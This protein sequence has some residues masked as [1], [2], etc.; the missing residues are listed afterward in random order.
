VVLGDV[1]DEQGAEVASSLGGSALFAHL[2][3]TSPEDWQAV[4]ARAVGTF[5]KLTALVNN[6]GVHA[7]G[8]IEEMALVEYERI[9]GVNQIGCWLGMKYAAP[10]IREA[11]GGAIVNISSTAGLAGMA[12]RS[13][14]GATKW[15]IR[16]MSKSAALELGPSRIRVNCVLPGAVATSMMGDLGDEHFRSQ[17]VPR[18]GLPEDVAQ[19]VVFLASEESS[20]C[21]GAEFVLDGGRGAGT[22]VA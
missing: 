14:Y 15:A 1:L 19:L 5:G 11:G 6:A 17:P 21:T 20:Y 2:D 3:V 4:V 22:P 7:L 8:L 10:A 13:A 12:G 16:G 18:A 9:I